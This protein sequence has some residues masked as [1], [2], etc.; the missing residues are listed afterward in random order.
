MQVLLDGCGGGIEEDME[1]LC[2]YSGRGVT[3]LSSDMDM[4]VVF[5]F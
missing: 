1:L 4:N 2:F 3:W 5:S